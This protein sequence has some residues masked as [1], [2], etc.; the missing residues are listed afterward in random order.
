[1]LLVT[2]RAPSTIK[3]CIAPPR[4]I[5]ANK[6]PISEALTAVDFLQEEQIHVSLQNRIQRSASN[7]RGLLA[8]VIHTATQGAHNVAR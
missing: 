8:P 2:D 5:A 4:A 3:R 6:E 7:H 1:M